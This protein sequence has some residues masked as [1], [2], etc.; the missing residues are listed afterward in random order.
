MRLKNLAWVLVLGTALGFVAITAKRWLDARQATRRVAD[1]VIERAALLVESG[2]AFDDLAR[3]ELQAKARDVALSWRIAESDGVVFLRVEAST[4]FALPLLLVDGPR[5]LVVAEAVR[6]RSLPPP[7]PPPPTLLAPAIVAVPPPP[8]EA[9]EAP[10]DERALAVFTRIEKKSPRIVFVLDYSGSMRRPLGDD[11]TLFLSCDDDRTSHAVLVR[12]VKKLLAA[13]PG[14]EAG[15]VVF[16]GRVL[17]RS[18]I[19]DLDLAVL[20]PEGGALPCPCG[21]DCHTASWDGLAR[22]AE[23]FETS[24][25]DGARF[26]VFVSDGQPSDPTV[27]VVEGIARTRAAAARLW[28]MDA[29]IFTLQIENTRDRQPQL[30]D[31]M[32]SVSGAPRNPGDAAYHASAR[33]DD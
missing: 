26:V 33:S 27:D 28:D 29:T 24:T 21:D 10:S 3:A 8:P 2:A 32:V 25:R 31:F 11:G 22:A 13:A 9:A 5:I 4:S 15:M 1:E 30:R 18:P 6:R 7:P 12:A 23:L 20:D 16:A 19:G 14:V 17:H